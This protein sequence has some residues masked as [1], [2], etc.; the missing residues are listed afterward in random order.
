MSKTKRFCGVAVKEIPTNGG[1]LLLR[2][3]KE[4]NFSKDALELGCNY[5]CY[6]GDLG[7]FKTALK[8]VKSNFGL[9]LAQFPRCEHGLICNLRLSKSIK[10]LIKPSVLCVPGGGT[11]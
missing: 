6:E 3:G 1:Q 4:K 5:F 2:C 7:I 10:N 11:E 8:Q 9:S